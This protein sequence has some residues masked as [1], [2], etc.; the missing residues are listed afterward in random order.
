MIMLNQIAQERI[1]VTVSNM[2]QW[3]SRLLSI[4]SMTEFVCIRSDWFIW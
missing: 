1:V 4:F 3:E 2:S